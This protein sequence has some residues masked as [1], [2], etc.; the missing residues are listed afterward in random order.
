MTGSTKA[1]FWEPHAPKSPA[2]SG[3]GVADAAAPRHRGETAARSDPIAD[4]RE[5]AAQQQGASR[6]PAATAPSSRAGGTPGLSGDRAPL[7]QGRGPDIPTVRAP[8]PCP[9]VA[10]CM[11][12]HGSLTAR[13]LQTT[14]RPRGARGIFFW[15]TSLWVRRA[16]PGRAGK[17]LRAGRLR[18][19][20]NFAGM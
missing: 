19:S 18:P 8:T 2:L 17:A 12:G 15:K 10:P 6:A 5:S 3:A 1:E 7:R 14:P 9:L 20:G 4:S 16:E 11:S 13:W